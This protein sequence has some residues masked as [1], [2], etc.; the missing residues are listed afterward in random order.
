LEIFLAVADSGRFSL[1]AQKRCTDQSKITSHGK[2]LE[3]EL[4]VSLLNRH[5]PVTLSNAGHQLHSY[6]GQ[7]IARHN[8]AKRIFRE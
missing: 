4:G 1:A 8:K 2:K 3:E 5:N 6:A 7:T